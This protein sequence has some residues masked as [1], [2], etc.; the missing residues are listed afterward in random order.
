MR[1]A[2]V[3][4][5]VAVSYSMV[6]GLLLLIVLALTSAVADGWRARATAALVVDSGP[7]LSPD[8]SQIAFIRGG[9]G[10][11]RLWVMGSDGSDQQPLVQATRFSW[12]ARS[13]VLLFARGGPRV[14]RVAV[15]GGPPVAARAQIGKPTARSHRR[16]VFVRAH[17]IYLRD[18]DGRVSEL[19]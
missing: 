4:A 8:G 17:H 16:A 2:A 5:S 10:A 13:G 19:T 6:V 15:G 18:E 11:P 3:I 14:F 9:D 12:D 1:K 7:Q